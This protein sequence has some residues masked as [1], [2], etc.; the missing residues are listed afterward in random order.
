MVNTLTLVGVLAQEFVSTL[1][2]HYIKN[3]S[4]SDKPISD[5]SYDESLALLRKILAHAQLGTVEDIQKLTAHWVPVPNWINLDSITIPAEFLTTSAQ[6]IEKELS[7]T[8]IK[9][10]GGKNWWKWRGPK[11]NLMADWIEAKEDSNLRLTGKLDGNRVMFFVH[12]GAYYFG[13]PRTHRYQL[14]R[15]ARMLKARVFAPWYRVAP[16]FPFPCGVYDCLA[17]YLYLLTFQ[18][19]STIILAGDSAGGGMVMSMLIVMRNQGIPLPAGAVLISPWVDLTHSFPSVAEDGSQDYIPSHASH[20]KPSTAWPPPTA[21]DILAAQK[22]FQ[23]ENPNGVPLIER[24]NPVTW[25]SN[26]TTTQLN[27]KEIKV[28]DQIHMYASNHLL[29]HPL[30]SSVLQPTLGGLPPLL[31]TVGGGEILRDEQI[32]LAHKAANPL[33]YL[34]ADLDEKDREELMNFEP[35]DVQLQVWDDLCHALPALTFAPS[36][37]FIYKSIA[38]FSART[39]S[40]AQGIEIEIMNDD[41]NSKGRKHVK[42]EYKPLDPDPYIRN[43]NDPLPNFKNHMI[44]QRVDRYGNIYPLEDESELPA[45]NVDPSLI[46]KMRDEPFMKW[47][48]MKSKWEIK[49]ASSKRK[50]QRRSAEDIIQNYY[51]HSEDGEAPPLTAL[52]GRRKKNNDQTDCTSSSIMSLFKSCK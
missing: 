17:S 48:E 52:A 39:L 46:G 8:G 10:I 1:F 35:T 23:E 24:S 47:V 50:M 33:K 31:I 42:D 34:P 3:R 27:G 37:K 45:C 44:R 36:A 26:E 30:V 15:H 19:P 18:D 41:N 51:S 6:A 22:S 13:S 21:Q 7:E 5:L 28:H 14:Q 12:G 38:Q 49:F 9:Q 40:K 4:K 16:Q 2:G 20:H 25:F 32:Y 29:L 11:G 43:S